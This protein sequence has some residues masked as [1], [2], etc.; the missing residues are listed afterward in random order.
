MCVRF[1]SLAVLCCAR[2]HP[3]VHLSTKNRP[4][5]YSF[6]MVSQMN[7]NELGHEHFIGGEFFTRSQH[8]NLYDFVDGIYFLLIFW[9]LCSLNFFFGMSNGIVVVMN[10]G[11]TSFASVR[12]HLGHHNHFACAFSLILHAAMM[13]INTRSEPNERSKSVIWFCN[14]RKA[15]YKLPNCSPFCFVFFFVRLATIQCDARHLVHDM[16]T[17][18]M[19]NK[20]KCSFCVVLGCSFWLTRRHIESCVKQNRRKKTK[21]DE[22]KLTERKKRIELCA[23]SLWQF[24]GLASWSIFGYAELFHNQIS[25]C[26]DAAVLPYFYR[27]YIYWCKVW[28]RNIF[29]FCFLFGLAHSVSNC[30]SRSVLWFFLLARYECVTPSTLFHTFP[31]L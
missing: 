7:V 3:F 30:C 8:N 12:V 13:Q 15:G 5:K 4:E 1:L 6:D 29:F 2:R 28:L 10:K 19:L 31:R 26:F 14:E 17:K 25:L 23:Q 11:I 22:L 16:I 27:I 20:I 9:C 18:R 24:F 21:N